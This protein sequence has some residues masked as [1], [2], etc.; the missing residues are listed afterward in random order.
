MKRRKPGRVCIGD[1]YI[2]K[3]EGKRN[4]KRSS[5]DRWETI[6]SSKTLCGRRVGTRRIDDSQVT[7]V[8]VGGRYYAVLPDYVRKAP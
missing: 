2:Y 6:M 7:V 5:S 4:W 8:T 3:Y 1:G